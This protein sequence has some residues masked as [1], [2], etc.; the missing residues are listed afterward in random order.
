MTS[1]RPSTITSDPHVRYL[2]QVLEDVRTAALEV[3]RFQ[4][5]F[6]WKPWQ[7]R[8]LLNSVRDGIP[9]GSLLVWRT[10]RQGVDTYP[11]F[12]PNAAAN[13]TDGARDYLL[14][15]VQ[16]LSTL[17]G[18]L[19]PKDAR[20][21]EALIEADEGPQDDQEEDSDYSASYNLETGEF[22]LPADETGAPHHLPMHLL[23]D[24]KGL[25][26]FQRGLTDSRSEEWIDRA[27]GLARA[28]REYKV[29]IIP[30]VTDDLGMATR[31]F[32]RINSE[33]TTMGELH[34]LHA[35]TWSPTNNLLDR[36]RAG[37]ETYLAPLGWEALEDDVIVK[38]CKAA[39][40]F[41]VYAQKN[42][43]DVSRQ[44]A[45]DPSIVDQVFSNT[46]R[47]ITFIADRCG[48]VRPTLLP[49]NMQLAVLA[50]ALRE[51][52]DPD[53]RALQRLHSW[54]WATTY[55]ELFSAIGGSRLESVIE[56]VRN[57]ASG[58]IAPWPWPEPF[59][60]KPLPRTATLRGA[61]TLAFALRLAELEPRDSIGNVIPDPRTL[62]AERSAQAFPTLVPA[63][64]LSKAEYKS[65]AN[66]VLALPQDVKRLRERLLREEKPDG[67]LLESHAITI[68]AHEALRMQDFRRFLLLRRKGIEE[69]E[70]QFL[71]PLVPLL[72]PGS[73]APPRPS[74]P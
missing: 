55:G 45:E 63:N 58:R 12:S 71:G 19:F 72:G 70:A 29:P 35:L 26:R 25:L 51:V 3:P 43:D 48:V 67:R 74:K 22:L 37:K 6:I 38:A 30:I 62:L 65:P 69:I 34:M 47:A 14:D 57:V 28:F 11:M 16:R 53:E 44:L 10:A 42:V 68:E 33:G 1:S 61:R 50:E 20:L 36:F 17:L 23:Y 56:A 15:G 39:L 9:M 54:F 32:Q 73:I 13:R 64:L 60:A 66:R 24:S 21:A 18:A 4:R 27:D 46:A 59:R 31:T 2:Q 41:P 52:P 5:P 7:R 40:G 8:E 49:Y